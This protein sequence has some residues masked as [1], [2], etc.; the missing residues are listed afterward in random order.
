M[1]IWSLH[2]GIFNVTVQSYIWTISCFTSSISCTACW[3]SIYTLGQIYYKMMLTGNDLGVK[4]RA[5]THVVKTS[6]LSN[7]HSFLCSFLPGRIPQL[8]LIP[9]LH[10]W[11][12]LSAEREIRGKDDK[13]ILQITRLCVY[14]SELEHDI[15]SSSM[16]VFLASF[17]FPSEK[18]NTTAKWKYREK[19]RKAIIIAEDEEREW[20]PN[21]NSHLLI[22]I[23]PQMRARQTLV[24]LSRTCQQLFQ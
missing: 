12:W 22:F 1:C 8:P 17:F 21:R 18:E 4:R 14:Y 19:K 9:A 7:R 6:S 2:G 5:M 23:C 20:V 24:L 13:S 10:M 15:E 16:L 11:H 3:K